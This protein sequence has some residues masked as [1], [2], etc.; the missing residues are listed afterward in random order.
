VHWDFGDGGSAD[1]ETAQH[2][3][4]AGAWTVYA[5][6]EKLGTIT[7]RGVALR[8]PPVVGYG[9]RLTFRGAIVPAIGGEPVV[10]SAS[11]RAVG[12]TLTRTDGTFRLTTRIRAPGPYVAAW[13]DARSPAVSTSV[14]PR[15]VAR[16][17][18]AET[19]GAQLTVAAHLVPSAA[20]TV[21]IEV[22]RGD[23]LVTDVRAARVRLDTRAPAAY[24]IRISST[25]TAGYTARSRT[26]SATVALPYL[27]RGSVGPSVRALEQRLRELH[28]ALLRVD[29]VYGEDTYD[30]V[31]AFQK[32]NGLPRTGEVTPAVWRRLRQAAIP[33]ARYGGNHVEVDKTRQVLFEV[34]QG[35]VALVVPVSTGATGNTPVGLWHV[36]SRVAGWSWV[37]WY[38]TYFLRGFAIHGYPEVPTYPA[39]HGCVRVPMWIATRLF[40]MHP[41]GFPIYIYY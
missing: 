37:L 18:G 17:V 33:R 34:R 29:G 30:A 10:V 6:S 36:Y 35:S 22:R 38:P 2:T 7:A 15:L 19:V 12:S 4:A 31:V 41:N 25:P 21:R 8:M 20:G 9:H 28:Y 3:F 23:K 24:R 40:D 5:G 27:R 14:K 1:G 16:V 39:S 13:A 32:V 11:G 26:L